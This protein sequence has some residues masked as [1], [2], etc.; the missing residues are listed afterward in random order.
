MGCRPAPGTIS[1]WQGRADENAVCDW[2]KKSSQTSGRQPPLFFSPP[3]IVRAVVDPGE[4]KQDC[5]WPTMRTRR[6]AS[7]R[8][9]IK[10]YDVVTQGIR[11]LKQNTDGRPDEEIGRSDRSILQG[12]SEGGMAST[13]L[14]RK[15]HGGG[16][17][18]HC[19]IVPSQITTM[20]C[21]TRQT[22]NNAMFSAVL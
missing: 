15:L 4:G 2:T 8:H 1:S 13:F 7:S 21:H 19:G 12:K 18:G 22:V 3:P 20:V 16:N 11:C 5:E 14:K 10:A 9:M 6:G 17:G